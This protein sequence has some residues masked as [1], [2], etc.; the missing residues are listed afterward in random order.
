VTTGELYRAV[1]AKMLA[2]AA[3]LSREK[4]ELP[5]PALPGWSVKDAYAHLTGLCGDMLDGRMEGAGSAAWTAK[6][7]AARSSQ[8]LPDVCAEWLERGPA[9][10]AWLTKHAATFV[11]FDVWNHHQ[12]VRSAVGLRGERDRG[13]VDYVATE[14]LDAFD[15]RFRE[16]GVPALRVTTEGVD[17]NLGDGPPDATLT[18]TDYELV[19]ILFGRRSV[20]QITNAGW[21]GDPAAYLDHL[22]LFDPPVSD[23]AD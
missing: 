17:R 2:L 21:T 8:D 11:A 14:A 12:D 19:R 16:A 5:V 15:G 20:A 6:Q 23:L 3:G 1:R 4:S 13:Q 18:T 7:V 22:H 9:L 10:D